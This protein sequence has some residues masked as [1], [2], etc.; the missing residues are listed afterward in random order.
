ML[1][2]LLAGEAVADVTVQVTGYSIDAGELGLKISGDA[3]DV[4]LEPIGP[5]LSFDWCKPGGV[6]AT[7]GTA[8]TPPLG[9]P[10]NDDVT[11]RA[12]VLRGPVTTICDIDPNLPAYPGVRAT[13]A[14]VQKDLAVGAAV[15]F[16][17]GSPAPPTSVEL[18]TASLTWTPPTTNTDGSALKDLAGFKVYW[19][20]SPGSY[21]NSQTLADAS[22]TTYTVSALAP[23]PWYFVVTAYSQSGRESAYSNAASKTIPATP[24]QSPCVADPFKAPTSLGWPTSRVG[25]RSL[26]WDTPRNVVRLD[27]SWPIG[28]KQSATWTDD[29]GCSV[30]VAR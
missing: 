23:G 18:G 10:N 13:V 14:G 24:P 28:G 4:R 29:R 2:L 20:S 17:T 11:S 30:T 12:I 21:P 27:Y 9:I 5:D 16:T 7:T 26:R 19:G 6:D 15:V 25:S 1:A 3:V 22:L 8:T